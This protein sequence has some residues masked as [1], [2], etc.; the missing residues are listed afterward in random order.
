MLE[1]DV[2]LK[3]HLYTARIGLHYLRKNGG[4]DFV[5]VSSI[6]GFKECTGLAIYTASKHG[7]IG[8]LRGLH[9]SA[10][11]D[12]IRMNVVCPWMTSTCNLLVRRLY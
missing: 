5:L 10:I 11:K 2:N 6:A 8:I 1:I 12:N 9:L 3:G 7:V 4:G